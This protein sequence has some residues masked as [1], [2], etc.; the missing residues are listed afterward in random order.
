MVEFRGSQLEILHTWGTKYLTRSPVDFV[1]L[2]GRKITH[3]QLLSHR[4][5]GGENQKGICQETAPIS[6]LSDETVSIHKIFSIFFQVCS[7]TL[8]CLGLCSLPAAE[9]DL[10]GAW[11]GQWRSFRKLLMSSALPQ[12]QANTSNT[13]PVKG[14]NLD[15]QD[16]SSWNQPDLCLSKLWSWLTLHMEVSYSLM[17]CRTW[18]T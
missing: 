11:R 16:M 9:G 15:L 6:S 3:K 4:T 2:I 17:H 14:R 13:E 5:M 8:A 18:K 7:A 10:T 12:C 1:V